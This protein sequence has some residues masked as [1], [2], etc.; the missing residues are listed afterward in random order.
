MSY[1]LKEP[2]HT[3]AVHNGD[4][5]RSDVNLGL[6]DDSGLQLLTNTLDEDIWISLCL[7]DLHYRISSVLSG[8]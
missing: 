8:I 1:R 5:T 7:D 2:A 4:G 6:S 3:R